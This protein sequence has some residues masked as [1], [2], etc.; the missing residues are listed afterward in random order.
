MVSPFSRDPKRRQASLITDIEVCSL[1]NQHFGYLFRIF[2]NGN[3]QGS[4]AL[5]S[6]RVHIGPL[7]Q[8]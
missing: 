6:C 7:F 2:L 1:L 4:F 8:Q 5:L 3:H